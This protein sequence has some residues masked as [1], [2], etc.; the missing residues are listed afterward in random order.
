MYDVCRFH[1]FYDEQ[2]VGLNDR[3]RCVPLL[4]FKASNSLEVKSSATSV[5]M[6]AQT[7]CIRTGEMFYM[8]LTQSVCLF[9]RS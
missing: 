2:G 3:K 1:K 6:S 5:G 7:E 9:L 8:S 4:F